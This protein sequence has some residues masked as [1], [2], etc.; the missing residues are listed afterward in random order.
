MFVWKAIWS[1]FFK[2]DPMA[3]EALW[4]SSIAR[5]S[6]SIRA[7]PSSAA[8]RASPARRTASCDWS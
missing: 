5:R 1:M 6:S 8:A 3:V 2:I 7:E 4:I